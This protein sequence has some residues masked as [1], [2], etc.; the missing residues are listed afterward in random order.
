[1]MDNSINVKINKLDKEYARKGVPFHQRPLQAVMDILNISSVIG[2]IEHPQFNYIVNIYG[3][4]IP[5]TIVTWPGMGTGLVTSIDRV[6]SFTMG[7]AYGCPEINVDRGLGFDSHEQWSSWCRNDRKIVADSYF[8][9]ADAYDLIYGIDDLSH[10]ANPDVIAL[11]DLTASNL[12]V[13]AHTLPN[14]YI[15]GS[16][17]QPICMTVE[18]ALKGVLIHLGLSKS[19]IINLGHDHTALWE[20]LISKAGHRDD[21][22]IKNIIK[23]FPDYIDSRYKRSELSRIQTVKLALGAQFIAASTLRRVTQRDLALT[24]ELNNFPEHAIRQKFANSFS[25]GAW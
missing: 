8:A 11:L 5:E 6:K 21:V 3:Q 2:A 4:L 14:T 15:S 7:I 13:I 17:I 24:M 18:L 12:E 25:K 16:V 19:E 20:S 22:L 9:Y 23:R 10:S 1:M